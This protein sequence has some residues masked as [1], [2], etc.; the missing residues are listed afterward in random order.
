MMDKL[1]G[2]VNDRVGSGEEGGGRDSRIVG[3]KG[4]PPV[5]SLNGA[6]GKNKR[7]EW[8]YVRYIRPPRSRTLYQLVLLPYHPSQLSDFPHRLS[9]V[10]S[11]RSHLR[12]GSS[13]GRFQPVARSF[14]WR[15]NEPRRRAQQARRL[16]VPRGTPTRPSI[17]ILQRQ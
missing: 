10:N 12:L 8:S 5:V 15:W 4:N 3:G 7:E 14:A 2:S 13:S 6:R 1:R 16:F 9:S 11:V 17:Y